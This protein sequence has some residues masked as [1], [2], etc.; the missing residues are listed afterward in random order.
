MCKTHFLNGNEEQNKNK[1]YIK[2]APTAKSKK[3]Q[4]KK[5]ILV[6]NADVITK[7]SLV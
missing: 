5:K 6:N 7:H 4:N 3:C 1:L 2:P